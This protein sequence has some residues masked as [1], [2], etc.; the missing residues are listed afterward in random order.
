MSDWLNQKV[1]FIKGVGPQRADLL[2]TELSV[3][4][5]G[6][7]INYY[8]YRYDDRSK[9]YSIREIHEQLPVVQIKGKLRTFQ[10]AG[11]GKK[12][13]VAQLADAT[14]IVE[15]VW[16]QGA[17]FIVK[18]LEIGKEYVVFGKPNLFG[19][20][21]SIN[22]PEM[23]LL[24]EYK[25]QGLE[26]V[27]S[28]TERLRNRFFDSKAI[29][30]CLRILIDQLEGKLP[31]NLPANI[32]REYKLISHERAVRQIHFPSDDQA[33]SQALFRLKFE[34]LFFI[35]IRML[36]SREM[37]RKEQGGFIFK[38]VPTLTEFYNHHLPFDLTDAQKKVIKE[39]YKDMTSGKQMNRLLQ[40]DVGSGKTIVA[41]ICM[42]M[43][44][45]HSTQ[46]CLMAPTEILATQ[47]YHA[48][49]V[50]ADK[51]NI[52][53]ALLTGSSKKSERDIIHAGLKDNS[54][55]IIIGTHALLEEKVQ[56]HSLGLAVIDEQH[57][58]G[59]AQRAR[60]W[61]K[62]EKIPP[63]I[64]VMTA[65]PI[66]RTLAMT[67]YGDLDVSTIDQLPQGRK[68]IQTVHRNDRH[69]LQVFGFIRQQIQAG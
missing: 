22:H 69:R 20:K 52:P 38:T 13:L 31:E 32:I 3:F 35:Q 43:A 29:S 51:M 23:E 61:H 54:L 39:I 18:K 63:H 45:D 49:K 62:N 33:L 5:Y 53:I 21:L 48:L 37:R 66:P 16:F 55:K 47:H 46:A 50:F 64:L 56:F 14:G 12:R 28:T 68:P 44:L 26:P 25:S 58:F 65:T 10:M 30:K 57:R 15:L 6:D 19:S 42:L 60:L 40:G 41:F 67:L 59:V 2:H 7:F 8:P 4:T 17:Q 1:E 36:L 24:S 34:E 27:Y 11:S 9:F